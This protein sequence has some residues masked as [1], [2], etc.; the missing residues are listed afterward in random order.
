[1]TRMRKERI[2]VWQWGRFGAGPRYAYE[3]AYGLRRQGVD[4]LLSLSSNAEIMRTVPSGEVDLPFPTYTSLPQF[5]LK[6]LVLGRLL[7]KLDHFV[8]SA[9]P[10]VAIC[11]MPGIWDA[12]V[13]RHLRRK[14]VPVITIVHD[15]Q[16]HPGDVFAPVYW[17]QRLLVRRSAGIITLCDFVAGELARQGV[18]EGRQHAVIPHIPFLFPDLALP[19]PRLPGYPERPVMRLLLAGRLQAYKGVE[20][21][22]EA[23][24][25]L[26]GREIE[27]RIVG[28]GT[29]LALVG[30]LRDSRVDFRRGWQS[31]RELVEHLDWCDLVIAPYV[32][33]SQSG[34]VALAL[35]RWRPVVATPVGGLPEQVAHGKTGLIASE[36]SGRAIANAIDLFMADPELYRHCR[37]NVRSNARTV[38]SWQAVAMQFMNVARAVTGKR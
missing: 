8:E 19:P 29:S 22:L 33:A 13:A 31:E 11:A 9:R 1:M 26:S 3:L 23:L 27:A 38:E 20:L 5:T 25:L 17:V 14:G 35:D 15:A 10:D 18:L 37:N 4:V 21:F 28:D 34:I 7:R 36:I 12:A 30:V 2:F 32:E 24:T 6:S 16:R